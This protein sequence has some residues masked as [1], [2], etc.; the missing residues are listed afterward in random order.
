MVEIK[1]QDILEAF[2]LGDKNSGEK[3]L[4]GILRYAGKILVVFERNSGEPYTGFLEK[5]IF[6]PN[7]LNEKQIQFLKNKG[8]E[9]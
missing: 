8:Y 4:H 6:D 3:V 1:D 2:K 7:S 5:S 9:I